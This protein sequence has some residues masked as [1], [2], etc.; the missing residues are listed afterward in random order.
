MGPGHVIT[1]IRATKSDNLQPLLEYIQ[2]PKKTTLSISSI[3]FKAFF[4]NVRPCTSPIINI[5][6]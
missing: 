2:N 3:I 4:Q 5:F 6:I 1:K